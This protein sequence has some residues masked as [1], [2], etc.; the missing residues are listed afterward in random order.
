LT[1]L[2]NYGR[3]NYDVRNNLVINYVY[4]LPNVASLFEFL[5]HAV[6][7]ALLNDWQ[8]SGVTIFRSGPP[9]GVGFSIPGIGSPQLT[10]SYTE[11]ARV[12]LVGDPTLGTSKSPYD[13]INPVA[14]APP[15]VGS[16]GMDSPA[17]YLTKPGTNNWDMSAQK[18]VSLNERLKLQIRVDAFNVF[19][20][21]QF[22][23]VH[24]TINFSGLANPKPTNLPFDANGNLIDRNG[25]GT[26]S[27]VRN[28][29]TLQLVTRLVF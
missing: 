10:G 11:G 8:I 28:P 16:I 20:H 27:G 15:D 2:A 7:R 6:T 1:R 24:S 9:Y 13:R 19:N 22:T 5:H 23:G 21:P 4:G 26:I 3:C 12:K 17:N 25:F 14:F 29:R 18:N